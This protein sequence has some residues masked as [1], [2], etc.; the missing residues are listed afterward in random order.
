MS[1]HFIENSILNMTPAAGTVTFTQ[2]ETQE[3]WT[4]PL[5]GWA[6]VITYSE[7]DKDLGFPELEQETS[8]EPVI[9]AED[10]Y[11]MAM[12]HYSMDRDGGF[13][14]RIELA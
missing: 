11:P 7:V 8:I 9:L 10:A 13:D 12:G 1:K 4:L 6:V 3:T 14:Y 2:R 5:I